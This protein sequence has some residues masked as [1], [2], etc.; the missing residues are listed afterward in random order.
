MVQILFYLDQNIQGAVAIM[1]PE[2]TEKE[3]LM[4]VEGKETR[5]VA[6]IEGK[7][8]NL[9][10]D[11]IERGSLSERDVNWFIQDLIQEGYAGNRPTSWMTVDD[12]NRLVQ[13][14][15]KREITIVPE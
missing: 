9:L 4:R 1:Y 3:A 12:L 7:V 13:V 2:E 14:V 5:G 10:S 6:K 15:F 11:C 8:G